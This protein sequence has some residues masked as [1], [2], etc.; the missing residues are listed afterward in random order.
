MPTVPEKEPENYSLEEM[1]Q[2]LKERGH[3]EG[4]MVTRADGTVAVKVRKRKRRST[5]PHKEQAK[6]QQRM[7]MLQLALAF[8]LI[9]GVI[10]LA[11][12]M[13][14]YYNSNAFREA[15]RDKIAAW[16]AAE[17]E[18]AEFTVTPN[19]ARFVTA[20]FTWPEGNYLRQLQLSQTDA[21]LDLSSF[22]GSKWGGTSVRAKT[23]KLSFSA[24]KPDA[25][26]RIGES[27]GATAFPFAFASY[28]CESLN[29]SGLAKDRQPW[30]SV[31]GTEASLTKTSLGAQTRFVGGV[32]KIAG[33]QP[34]LIDRGNL[35]FEQ[36]QMK[37]DNM[38]LKP[39]KGTGSLEL[40]NSIDLYRAES[41]KLEVMLT[42]FP[43]E[44]LLGN[45][46]DL[47]VIGKVDTPRDAINRLISFVPGDFSS[48]QLQIGF[49]GSERDALTLIN[50][51]FLETL[52]TEFR[53]PDYSQ[54]YVFSD[55]V[56]GELIRTAAST[57]LQGLLLEKKGSFIIRGE[58]SVTNGKLGGALDVGMPPSQFIDQETNPALKTVFSRQEDGYQWC[59]VELSGVPG[60]PKDN[61]AQQLEQALA[62]SPPSATPAPSAPPPRE[63]DIEKE[64]DGN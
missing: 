52:S 37:I 54:Q 17:V 61:F 60:Q 50:L 40:Q 45:E 38:R 11:V 58:I 27:P 51:P 55:R 3:D 4:E 15:T 42:E 64:L 26:K 12:G 46:L 62:S 41:S 6:R 25:A 33:F 47:L 5:Q 39:T 16:S 35:T 24:A 36:G 7:R 56:E 57:R 29:I 53:N 48:L 59:R 19:N 30:M 20:N 13:L 10:A 32:L 1:M 2:R 31:E 44:A 49:F 8:C 63:L 14:L 43:I 21:N 22:I 18:I 28:R 34:L 9:T 23:G